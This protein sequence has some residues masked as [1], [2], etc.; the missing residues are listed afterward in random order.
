MATETK[1]DDGEWIWEIPLQMAELFRLVNYYEL[2]SFIQIC[3]LWSLNIATE[4]AV[5]IV[6]FPIK[7]G[8]FPW[9]LFTGG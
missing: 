5:N 1:A 2:F 8:D 7:D 6:S 3:T 9:C 4:M